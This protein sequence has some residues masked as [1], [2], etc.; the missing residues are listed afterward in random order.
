VLREQPQLFIVTIPRKLQSDCFGEKV[1]ANP[2]ERNK[3]Y[4]LD[5]EAFHN[6]AR[7]P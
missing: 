7:A 3:E 2:Q 5:D 1:T 6:R 4:G